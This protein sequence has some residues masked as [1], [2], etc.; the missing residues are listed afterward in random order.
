MHNSSI[1]RKGR[2]ERAGIIR[3]GKLR[4]PP[5]SGDRGYA[6][7]GTSKSVA[8]YLVHKNLV[9]ARARAFKLCCTLACAAQYWSKRRWWRWW[10]W[11]RRNVRSFVVGLEIYGRRD[12]SRWFLK[13]AHGEKR[14]FAL[15]WLTL[16][17]KRML[18][19]YLRGNLMQKW[20]KLIFSSQKKTSVSITNN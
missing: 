19:F 5:L 9:Q 8:L 11:F 7:A 16:D 6:W 13:F 20:N 2:R 14:K 10:R 12:E 18:W 4:Y 17:R 3:Y 15:K 1:A